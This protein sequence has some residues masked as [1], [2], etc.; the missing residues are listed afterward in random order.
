MYYSEM[1][2]VGPRPHAIKHNEQYV[3]SIDDLMRRHYVKPGITGLA[4]ISGFR[5]E[6]PS[7]EIMRKRIHYDLEYIRNWSVALDIKIMIITLFKGIINNN[8]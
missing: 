1:S 5:G 2:L 7:T 4:Q 6:V 8:P 3:N